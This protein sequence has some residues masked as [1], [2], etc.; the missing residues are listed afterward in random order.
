MSNLDS[1]DSIAQ[2]QLFI[3]RHAKSSW[4]DPGTADFD[5]P[6]NQRGQAAA[7]RMGQRLEERDMRVDIILAS[8]A[9]R[10]RETIERLESTWD[11]QAQVIWEKQLYLA[12]VP[13]LLEHVAALDTAWSR[14]M[15]IGHNPGLSDLVLHLSGDPIDMPTA[16]IIMLDGP[17]LSWREALVHRPWKNRSTW[18]PK[19]ETPC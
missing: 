18:T 8:T 6:L 1:L 10:V 9:R 3:M 15:L 4:N 14:V 11:H 13:T 19:D 2:R 7:P 12:S 5:R 16:A 17:T